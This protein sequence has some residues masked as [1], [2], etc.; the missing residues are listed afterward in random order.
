VIDDVYT[1]ADEQREATL[2]AY[3]ARELEW[4]RR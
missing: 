2:N 3:A 4:E 1:G